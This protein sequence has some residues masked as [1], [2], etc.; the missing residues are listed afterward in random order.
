MRECTVVNREVS[1]QTGQMLWLVVQAILLFL[2]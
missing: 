1:D 2:S